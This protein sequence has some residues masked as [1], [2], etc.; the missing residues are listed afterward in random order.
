MGPSVYKF[1][2]EMLGALSKLSSQLN[3]ILNESN[4]M[5]FMTHGRTLCKPE[6][7]YHFTTQ[8]VID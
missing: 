1:M 7:L 6:E 8:K 4:A 3:I 5:I 2:G